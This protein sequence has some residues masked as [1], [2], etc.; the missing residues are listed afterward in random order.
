M[1]PARDTHRPRRAAVV[2]SRAGTVWRVA[3]R[4]PARCARPGRVPESGNGLAEG[5]VSS[6]HG[7]RHA[8]HGLR[9]FGHVVRVQVGDV[10]IGVSVGAARG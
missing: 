9:G 7:D 10:R 3:V 2:S 8:G 1:A 5:E 6:G 4:Q